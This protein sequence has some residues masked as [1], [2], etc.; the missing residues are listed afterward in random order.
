MRPLPAAFLLLQARSTF[1]NMPGSFSLGLNWFSTVAITNHCIVGGLKQH[2]L[3]N[4]QFQVSQR[5]ADS[6]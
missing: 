4:F 2:R 3:N 1:K 5:S 6:T